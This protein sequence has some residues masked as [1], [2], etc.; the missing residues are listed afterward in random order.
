MQIPDVLADPEYSYGAQQIVGYRALL[1]VPIVLDEEFIGAIVVGRD[2]PGPFADHQATGEV[3]SAAL[4]LEAA[5]AIF[6][7]LG[8]VAPARRAAELLRP[9]RGEA[10]GVV[11]MDW[12]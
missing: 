9:D 12:A 5:L 2:T 8:A 10:V 6:E 11:T 7:R 3:D 4:E 1:G